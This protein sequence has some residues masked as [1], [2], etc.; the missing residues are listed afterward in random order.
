TLTLIPGGFQGGAPPAP[1]L[2]SAP[3]TGLPRP[4]PA[5]GLSKELIDDL[6][7]SFGDIWFE[8]ARHQM[9]LTVAGMLA[10]HNVKYD[11]AVAIITIASEMAGGDTSKRLKDV[12]DTYK[13]F[14]LGGELQGA[15]ALDKLIDTTFP[16]KF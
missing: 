9:A 15:P 10:Y 12:H 6:G 11:S 14:I 16:Q 3:G 4:E 7:K 13:K 8:G 2:P 5:I 1:A